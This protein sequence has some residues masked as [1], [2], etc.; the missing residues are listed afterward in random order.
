M[1]PP[2]LLV[3]TFIHIFVSI[4]R[5]ATFQ[6]ARVFSTGQRDSASYGKHKHDYCYIRYHAIPS[7]LEK[8]EK[9]NNFFFLLRIKA[10]CAK[11]TRKY[12]SRWWTGKYDVVLL[13]KSMALVEKYNFIFC[14]RKIAGQTI[15]FQ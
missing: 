5:T 4:T 2:H 10:V 8:N 7:R 15:L 1:N 14:S 12:K 3:V 6:G 13:A 9:K 11:V